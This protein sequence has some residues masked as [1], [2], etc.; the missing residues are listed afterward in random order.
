M[1]K[2]RYSF[3]VFRYVHDGVTGEFA[4]VGV[5]LYAPSVGF[6]NAICT[7]KYGRLSAFFGNVKGDHIKRLLRH[8]EIRIEELG[9]KMPNQLPFIENG[10]LDAASLVTRVLPVDDSALQ[11]SPIGWGTTD[12]PQVTLEQLYDRH[13]EFYARKNESVG[14]EDAEVLHVF[15]KPLA[16]HGIVKHLAPKR[17]VGKDFD[18]EFPLAWKNGKWNACEALSFDLMEPATIVD[19]ANRWLGRTISLSDSSEPFKLNLLLGKPRNSGLMTSFE[20]AMNI[21]NKMQC[22]HALFTEDESE[23]FARYVEEDLKDHSK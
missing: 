2:L 21:L 3:T 4:N 7:S 1:S 8:L 10:K 14:R 19:K 20:H 15:R 18:H 9:S 6:L 23:R 13:V 22:D 12:D 5:A 17:I 16:E 11:F